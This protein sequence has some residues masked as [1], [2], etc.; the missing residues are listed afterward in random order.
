[1]ATVPW[2]PGSVLVCRHAKQFRTVLTN[3]RAALDHAFWRVVIQHSGL[4]AQ[5]H[6]ITFPI[7]S[8]EQ[9]FKAPKKELAPLVSSE[10]WEVIEALQPFHGGDLAH[11]APLEVLRWLSKRS[12]INYFCWFGRV[13]ASPGAAVTV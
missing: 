5:P 4:P 13:V 8:T 12:Q 7:A 11:T 3:L 1:M 9:R 6:R 2:T 10:V